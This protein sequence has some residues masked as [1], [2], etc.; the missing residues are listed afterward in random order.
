VTL[1]GFGSFVPTE[2]K[3]RTG[4][5]PRTGEPVDIPAAKSARFTVGTKFKAQVAGR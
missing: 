3:A 1:P 4:R 2:R 5:N